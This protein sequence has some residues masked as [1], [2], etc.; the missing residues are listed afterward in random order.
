MLEHFSFGIPAP[1][2]RRIDYV[3]NT[4]PIL[5]DVIIP[6]AEKAIPLRL[7]PA[8]TLFVARYVWLFAM[9][10]AVDFNNESRGHAGKVR[11]V[12]ADRHLSPEMRSFGFERAEF[13]P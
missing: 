3:E 7:Q 5:P 8:R 11:D 13:T 12:R 2:K 10:R 4:R 9:L 6:E 1:V